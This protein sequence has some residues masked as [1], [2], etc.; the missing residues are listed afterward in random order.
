[1]DAGGNP[2]AVFRRNSRSFSLAA[3]LFARRDQAAIARIY[4][5]CRYLDDLADDTQTGDAQAL[6]RV[7]CILTGEIDVPPHS[8]EADFLALSK[9]RRIPLPP[10][11]KLIAALCNDCGPRSIKSPEELIQFAY[12]VAG[13]VGEL[14]RPVIDAQDDRAV[15]FAIDLGIALQL[16]NIVRDIAEDAARGRFYLPAEWVAPAVIQRALAAEENAVVSV[17]EAVQR[18]LQLSEK[19]YES[20]RRGFAYIPY[21]NRRVVFLAAALYQAIGKKVN[22]LGSGAWRQRTVLTLFEKVAVLGRSLAEYRRWQQHEWAQNPEP[23]HDPGLHAAL[24]RD[25]FLRVQ[26][27]ASCMP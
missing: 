27:S 24:G 10:A 12:G 19:Y 16:T 22:R 2:E 18:M 15:A 3:R 8:I 25:G 6:D 13:T 5:F 20:A 11:L 26:T 21:P 7:R 23:R 4:R 1:M 9:E 14:L 17:D